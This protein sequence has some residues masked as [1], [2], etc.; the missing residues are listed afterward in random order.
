MVRVSSA[1]LLHLDLNREATRELLVG[2]GRCWL[3]PAT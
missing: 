2:A 1:V 3:T